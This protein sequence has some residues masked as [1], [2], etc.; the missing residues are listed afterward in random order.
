MS[1]PD[2]AGLVEA[3]AL[4]DADSHLMESLD[5]LADYAEGPAAEVL[6][7]LDLGAA[8]AGAARQIQKG[9]DR[10]S[11]AKATEALRGDVL[12]SAKGWPALGAMNPAERAEVLDRT[13]IRQQLVFTTFATLL[14]AGARDLD[15]V[16]GGASAH[17]RGITDFCSGDERLLPVAFVPTND[18]ARAMACLEEALGLGAAAVWV[19]H[20]A[21]GGVSP[22]HLDWD[23]FWQRIAGASVPAVLHVGGG[24]STLPPAFHD[25]G[26][27][28]PPDHLG[29]GENLRAKD[30]PSIHHAPE[31]FLSTLVL[32]GVFHR[33]PDLRFGAIELGASWVPA[34]L[35][36]LDHAARSFA[37]NEPEIRKLPEL[38][39]DYVR[40]SMRFTP[41]C[42]EDVGWLI[43]QAGPELFLFS[44]D[45]PHPEGGR[46]P[47]TKFEQSLDAHGIDPDARRAFYAD[48]FATL[49]PAPA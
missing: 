18:R 35:R 21:M 14:F 42:F 19:P 41:F 29:G 31:T 20:R 39:S 4:C 17:N 15:V 33:V 34:F 44:T 22:G 10:Q 27:P 1:S 11:D 43:E 8:G 46:D 37:R 49:V 9:I 12:S 7:G 24:R 6:R 23:P 47:I 26:R 3:V 28:L 32:D 25:N 36:N 13:G 40:A 45:Y 30:F 16:Y 38:P 48:N 5:W 2:R